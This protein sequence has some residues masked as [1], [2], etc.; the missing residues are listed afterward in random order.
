MNR[1]WCA[2]SAMLFILS[3]CGE[4]GPDAATQAALVGVW[5]DV[6]TDQTLQFL[7]NGQGILD[8]LDVRYNWVSDAEI[9]IDYSPKEAR[10]NIVR[11]LVE[12]DAGTLR[13]TWQGGDASHVQTYKRVE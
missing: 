10:A 8:G 5:H 12:I 13:L 4:A 11:Y 7:E 2:L 3:A 6:S 9:E 1:L